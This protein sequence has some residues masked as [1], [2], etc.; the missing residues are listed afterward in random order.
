MF[1]FIHRC[2]SCLRP[3]QKTGLATEDKGGLA[4][5]SKCIGF[6]PI[7]SESCPHICMAI[8]QT[9]NILKLLPVYFDRN[10]LNYNI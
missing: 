2:P 4:F 7:H 5:H 9:A 6:I 10:H 3:I 8:L 1:L